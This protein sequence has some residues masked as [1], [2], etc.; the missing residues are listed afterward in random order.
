MII[1]GEFMYKKLYRSSINKV[2][3]GVAGGLGEYFNI[4]PVILRIGFVILALAWGFSIVIYIILAVILPVNYD[5]IYEIKDNSNSNMN[6]YF[7]RQERK[8]RDRQMFVGIILITIGI[9]FFLHNYCEIFNFWNIIP[10]LLIAIG[11]II[12]IKTPSIENSFRREK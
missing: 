8:K 9:G 1:F 5:E 11:I 6:D 12:L 4:D 3:F 2:F 10:L 7:E